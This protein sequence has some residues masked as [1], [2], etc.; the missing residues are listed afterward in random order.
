MVQGLL[1]FMIL[2]GRRCQQKVAL[3]RP[4]Q[5]AYVSNM[6]VD[7]ILKKYS[8]F[9]YTQFFSGG[10]RWFSARKTH[11]HKSFKVGSII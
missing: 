7:E 4:Y 2:G 6:E 5:K 1:K 11:F 10:S 9:T 8:L 3:N